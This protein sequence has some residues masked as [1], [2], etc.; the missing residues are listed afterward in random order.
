MH[1][2]LSGGARQ[3]QRVVEYISRVLYR[4]RKPV[5]YNGQPVTAHK[6]GQVEFSAYNRGGTAVF[7]PSS[8]HVA[9]DGFFI[10]QEG[11]TK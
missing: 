11:E 1:R 10:G 4:W 2:E 6:S 3:G 9:E 8:A 7:S 5:G